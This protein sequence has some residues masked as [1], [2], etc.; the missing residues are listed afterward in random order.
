MDKYWVEKAYR[1]IVEHN[2]FDQ[3]SDVE[4]FVD[5]ASIS[6]TVSIGLPGKFIKAGITAI[7][8][9]AK[10]DVTFIFTNHFPLEA[11]KVILR[12]D[13]PRCF[14]HINP[15]KSIVNPCIYEGNLS[16]L[17]QQSEWMN[18][19]LNQLI[20]WLEKAAS[21]DLLN[22]EQG[23]EPMRN[24]DSNGFMLYDIDTILSAFSEN[25]SNSLI[26][27]IEYEQRKDLIVTGSLCNNSQKK[28]RTYSLFL[29][30]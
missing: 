4:Y 27:S 16:E 10:E 26:N 19:Y 24:D 13:F 11:P 25:K 3:V 14:P 1:Y 17:L 6:A 20:D 8:V 9:K 2:S 15:S 29:N 30:N 12:D 18:G 21:N 23:W 7:G 28:K 5:Y 22:Y